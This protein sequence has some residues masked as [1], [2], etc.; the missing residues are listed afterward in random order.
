MEKTSRSSRLSPE[1][2]LE[3]IKVWEIVRAAKVG[4][5][6]A[7]IVP[8]RFPANRA[9][10]DYLRPCLSQPEGSDLISCCERYAPAIVYHKAG[11][12]CWHNRRA[13]VN[14]GRS[15]QWPRPR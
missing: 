9:L 13:I 15:R 4:N 5:P 1:E 12:L 11:C 3:I 8:A 2:I 10:R 6:V 14:E 7:V